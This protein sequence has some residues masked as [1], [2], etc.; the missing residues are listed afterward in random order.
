[1]GYDYVG[2][3]PDCREKGFYSF[4]MNK[5]TLNLDADKAM[6]FLNFRFNIDKS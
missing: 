6:Y 4:K 2:R 5:V 1:M 3:K